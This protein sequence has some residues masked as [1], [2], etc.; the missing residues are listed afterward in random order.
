VKFKG[1]EVGPGGIIIED[2][3][4]RVKEPD[5]GPKD[6]LR[7][8]DSEDGSVGGGRTG[9]CWRIRRRPE[10]PIPCSC[11]VMTEDLIK[12]SSQPSMTLYFVHSQA[13]ETCGAS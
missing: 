10:A 2:D 13:S 3:R 1:G 4:V 9:G 5:R 8:D 11:S 12:L 7:E 6:G